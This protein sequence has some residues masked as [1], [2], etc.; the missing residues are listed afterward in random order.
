MKIAV[1]T[2]GGRDLHRRWQESG[3]QLGSAVN[4]LLQ[5]FARLPEHEVHVLMAMREGAQ[6]PYTR[7]NIIFHDVPTPSW[8]MMKSFYLGAAASIKKYLGSIRPDVVH[9]QGTERECSIAAVR[10]GFPNLITIHGNMRLIAQVNHL[11]PFSYGWISAQLESLTLPR[12]DG[13]VCIS[14]HTEDAVRGRARRTWLVPNAVEEEFF[15]LKRVAGPDNT[16]ICVGNILRLKN[17][18][19]LIRA[20][21]PIARELQLNVLFLGSAAPDES[22]AREFE[23]LI[24]ER[25]WCRHSGYVDRQTVRE[26]L[27]KARCLIL[28]SLEENCPMVILEAMAVGLP[29]VAAKI[30]GIPDL[31]E[32]GKTGLLFNPRDAQSMRE[33][34]EEAVTNPA[35]MENMANAANFRALELHLP[36]KVAAR[37]IATYQELLSRA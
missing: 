7:G 13:V 11:P 20:L 23:S 17:Q 16:I 34:V 4:A 32:E 18:N 10:S 25:P 12:A 14:Q 1:I 22:Y 19:A 28:P 31:I 33:A 8:G 24:K 5:G 21:D 37:H 15:G 2:T 35:A 3:P 9:G 6:P 26:W 30:G 36:Q 29:V 27:T